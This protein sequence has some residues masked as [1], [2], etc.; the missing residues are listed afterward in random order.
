MFYIWGC[1]SLANVERE[2]QNIHVFLPNLEYASFCGTNNLNIEWNLFWISSSYLENIFL[3][4]LMMFFYKKHRHRLKQVLELENVIYNMFNGRQLIS[5][6]F[7]ELELYVEHS[8]EWL[9]TAHSSD[10]VFRL[11]QV[12][13]FTAEERGK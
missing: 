10:A 9:D 3:Y 8:S 2:N 5:I 1:F 12:R 7:F 11:Y 6:I 4:C 13:L